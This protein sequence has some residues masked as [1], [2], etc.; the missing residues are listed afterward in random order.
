MQTRKK[1]TQRNKN[2]IMDTNNEK[3]DREKDKA[4]K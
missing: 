2:Q 1:D 3:E 4:K